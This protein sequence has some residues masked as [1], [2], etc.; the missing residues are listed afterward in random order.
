MSSADSSHTAEDNKRTSRT[1]IEASDR[2]DASA[3]IERS[4]ASTDV[5]SAVRVARVESISIYHG[6]IDDEGRVTSSS[7]GS[8]E[9]SMNSSYA[10]I[11]DSDDTL[12]LS[13]ASYSRTSAYHDVISRRES[14]AARTAEY[15]EAA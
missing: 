8:T 9:S 6:S 4:I 11:A 12:V 7:S 15:D 2:T 10:A 14:D 1:I 13:S 5:S 3:V